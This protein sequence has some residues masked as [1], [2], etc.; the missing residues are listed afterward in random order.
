MLL[1]LLAAG[2]ATIVRR[3]APGPVEGAAEAGRQ[4]DSQANGSADLP[5]AVTKD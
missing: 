2:A 5:R 3:D 1:R 4:G